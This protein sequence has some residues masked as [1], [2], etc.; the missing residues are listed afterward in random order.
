MYKKTTQ[1]PITKMVKTVSFVSFM[2]LI[3]RLGFI[4]KLAP[5]TITILFLA[6]ICVFAI[7]KRFLY[8]LLGVVSF[9][10][11]VKLMTTDSNEEWSV[12]LSVLALF[13]VFAIIYKMIKNLLK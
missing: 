13:A 3:L 11:F 2:L 9:V 7:G 12:Y 1:K 10:L 6:L 4:G 5:F 8:A